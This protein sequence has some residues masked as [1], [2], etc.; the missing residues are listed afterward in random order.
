MALTALSVS[1]AGYDFGISLCQG[2]EKY[3]CFQ[4]WASY[5]DVI[6]YFVNGTLFLLW[7]SGHWKQI[8][9][10]YKDTEHEYIMCKWSW[11][12]S[13]RLSSMNSETNANSHLDPRQAPGQ[14]KKALIEEGLILT[15]ALDPTHWEGL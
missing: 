8:K 7:Y 5:S 10:S 9:L 15:D 4:I 6:T 3:L 2:V 11:G 13:W 14:L 1:I 12:R